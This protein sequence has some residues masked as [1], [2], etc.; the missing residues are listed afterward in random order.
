M[1]KRRPKKPK[2]RIPLPPKPPKVFKDRKKELSRKKCRA[3][4][5]E[6]ENEA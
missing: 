3:T 2:P 1:A 5:K 4:K 6:L